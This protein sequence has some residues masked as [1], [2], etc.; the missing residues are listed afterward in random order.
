MQLVLWPC[1][2]QNAEIPFVCPLSSQSKTI[3]MFSLSLRW[4]IPKSHTVCP[5]YLSKSGIQGEPYIIALMLIGK[6]YAQLVPMP[7]L[8]GQLLPGGHGIERACMPVAG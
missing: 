2:N 1:I 3:L 5:A 8:V 6:E 7:C 4:P